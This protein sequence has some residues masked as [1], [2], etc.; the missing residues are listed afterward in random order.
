MSS[1]APTVTV[2]SSLSGIALSCSGAIILAVVAVFLLA[3]GAPLIAVTIAMLLAV[4][5]ILVVL[6]DLPLAAEFSASGVTRR[7]LLRRQHLEWSRVL[8]VSRARV[9]VVRTNTRASGGLVA[10]I[11]RRRYLLVDKAESQ[12]EFE[13][14]RRVVGAEVCER[15]GLT[16][17]LGP[18]A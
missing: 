3:G 14:V 1:P 7:A 18:V 12:V 17:A 16:D 13:E 6:F 2:H 9:G 10:E 5:A 15:V 8:R 4:A 11:G